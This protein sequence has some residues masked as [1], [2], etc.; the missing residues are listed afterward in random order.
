ME[1]GDILNLKGVDQ[2]YQ[3]HPLWYGGNILFHDLLDFQAPQ[4]ILFQP[5]GNIHAP[6]QQLDGI[7]GAVFQ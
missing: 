2:V 3:G 7:D 1:I 6:S 5:S 4:D